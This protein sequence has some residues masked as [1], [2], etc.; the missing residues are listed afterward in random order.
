MTLAVR[1]S[2]GTFQR[3]TITVK[4]HTLFAAHQDEES[5]DRLAATTGG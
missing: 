4:E 1:G 2:Q 3:E 5:K